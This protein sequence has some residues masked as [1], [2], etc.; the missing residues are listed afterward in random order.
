MGCVYA[1]RDPET[2]ELR[3]VGQTRHTPEARLAG[4]L[5]GADVRDA[6]RMNKLTHWLR[7]LPC[8]PKLTILEADVPAE[9]LL[10]R[11]RHHIELWKRRGAKLVNTVHGQEVSGA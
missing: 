2:L 7:S 11:E 9:R 10:E 3:Y 6:K 1:L 5:M 8:A 4:H